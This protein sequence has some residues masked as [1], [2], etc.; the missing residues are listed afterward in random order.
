LGPLQTIEKEKSLKSSQ[1][2]KNERENDIHRKEG[3]E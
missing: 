3:K 2:N 1:E